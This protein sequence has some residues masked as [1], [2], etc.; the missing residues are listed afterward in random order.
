MPRIQFNIDTT[1]KD[2]IEHYAEIKG[3]R[4]AGELSRFAIVQYMRKNPLKDSEKSVFK[5]QRAISINSHRE[6]PDNN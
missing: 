1:K 3:F 6:T 2:E 5:T 4:N